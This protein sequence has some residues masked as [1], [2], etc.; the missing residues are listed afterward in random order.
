MG[1]LSAIKIVGIVQGSKDEKSY[2]D[3]AMRCDASKARTMKKIEMQLL[4]VL[5]LG[6]CFS[7]Y[8]I[9]SLKI[10]LLMNSS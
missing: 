1:V 5:G 10:S 8:F 9:V 7:L 3:E 4:K 2:L 6:L